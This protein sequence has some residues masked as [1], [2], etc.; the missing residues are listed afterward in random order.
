MSLIFNNK[1]ISPS[2][3]RLTEVFSAIILSIVSAEPK[4]L[5]G[6]EQG[7]YN[8]VLNSHY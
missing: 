4:I 5:G 1:L 6:G 2:P 7:L 3:K 8:F